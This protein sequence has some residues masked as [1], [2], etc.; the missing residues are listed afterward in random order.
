MTFLLNAMVPLFNIMLK[1][2][3]NFCLVE[4]VECEGQVY[5]IHFLRLH[6][7]CD[8]FSRELYAEKS[9]VVYM[10]VSDECYR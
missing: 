3:N 10:S 7:R 8:S 1:F 4:C 6:N 5:L 2:V 9:L